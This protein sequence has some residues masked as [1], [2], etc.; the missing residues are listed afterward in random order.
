MEG[1]RK[2]V[3]KVNTTTTV[4]SVLGSTQVVDIG[5]AAATL[6]VMQKNPLDKDIQSV[7]MA[8]LSEFLKEY[9]D[10]VTVEVYNTLI[11]SKVIEST[12]TA[13][14]QCRLDKELVC[15]GMTILTKL[16]QNGQKTGAT[17]VVNKLDAVSFLVDVMTESHD[18]KDITTM[19]FHLLQGLAKIKK[20]RGKL[21]ASGA[22]RGIVIVFESKLD[23]GIK[24]QAKEIMYI[25]MYSQV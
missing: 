12:V 23:G 5:G 11:R 7:G 9:W 13:M 19:G 1:R 21:I 6:S 4:L 8:K 24:R 18:D 25:L 15:H 2:R 22:M 20:L 14:K 10:C 16:S 3:P 17:I